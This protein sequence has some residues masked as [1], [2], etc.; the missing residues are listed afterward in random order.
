MSRCPLWFLEYE[1]SDELMDEKREKHTMALCVSFCAPFYWGASKEQA[2]RIENK[3]E[4]KERERERENREICSRVA[5]CGGA[6]D[7]L[8]GAA[9]SRRV[10]AGVLCCSKSSGTNRPLRRTRE[11][12]E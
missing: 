11:G 1:P 4:G 2:I 8:D 6:E 12:R 7:R 9:G 3:K 10:T 5:A